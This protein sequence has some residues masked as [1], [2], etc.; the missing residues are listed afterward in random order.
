[1]VPFWGFAG[2]PFVDGKK[3][4]CIVGGKGSIAVA[5]DKDTGKE[6]WRSLSAADQ[7]YSTPAL[8]KAGGKRQL[9]IW[10]G[11]AIHGLDPKTGK[12]YW[13]VPLEPDYGMSIMT[14]RKW[15]NYLFAGGNGGKAALLKLSAD[16]PAVE[17]VWRGK[18]KTALYPINSTPFLE[19]SYI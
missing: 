13:S 3:L 5:F 15:K 14:P 1:Q 10:D 11:Q 4:I 18:K 8:I 7:G 12:P 6:L 9:L 16:K 17:V 19:D 2:H